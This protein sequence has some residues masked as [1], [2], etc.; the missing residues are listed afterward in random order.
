MTQAETNPFPN[1]DTNKPTA[2]PAYGITFSAPIITPIKQA[3]AV[4]IPNSS[5]TTVII[6]AIT[7][8]SN[9]N[10]VK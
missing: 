4:V 6:T 3:F 1:S 7:K 5:S 2:G 9:S 10:P 8:L